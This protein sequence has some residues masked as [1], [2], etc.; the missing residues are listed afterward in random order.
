MRQ[1]ALLP[2]GCL[3]GSQNTILYYCDDYILYAS[4]LAVYV[5]NP[6]TFQVEKI[7]TNTQKAI[8]S[9]SVSPLS[10]DIL[11]VS[12]SDGAVT[13]WN[14]SDEQIISRANLNQSVSVAFDPFNQNICAIISLV[15]VRLLLW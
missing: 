9:I 15:N 3:L 14:I 11:A 1:I 5:L 13:T 6:K 7:L 12:T 10:K 4:S 8:T 2:S